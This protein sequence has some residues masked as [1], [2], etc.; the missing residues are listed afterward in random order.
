MFTEK[1]KINKV[2]EQNEKMFNVLI[3]LP[4]IITIFLAISCAFMGLLF[5]ILFGGDGIWLLVFWGGGAVYCLINHYTLK[6]ILSYK[7][8]HICYLKKQLEAIEEK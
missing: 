3:V 2:I 5:E 8:L 4:R 6:I 1:E 7:I